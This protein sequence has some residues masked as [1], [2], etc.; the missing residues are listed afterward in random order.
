[1][2]KGHLCTMKI[3]EEGERVH[4]ETSRGFC[5]FSSKNVNKSGKLGN[6]GGRV[7]GNLKRSVQN[8]YVDMTFPRSPGII[9]IIAST[10]NGY[11]LLSL[12]L[13]E[14]V[15]SQSPTNL[16]LN[17]YLLKIVVGCRQDDYMPKL[18]KTVWVH[19]ILPP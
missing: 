2:T 12:L 17:G 14:R 19:P 7:P 6:E 1:M 5:L 8:L 3:R 16:S 18:T 10:L 11:L 13:L 9:I 4:E 15:T